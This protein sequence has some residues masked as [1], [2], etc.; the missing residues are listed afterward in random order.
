V[1]TTTKGQPLDSTVTIVYYLYRQAFEEFHFGY[2]SA[3]AY[4]VFAVTMVI[5]AGMIWYSRR[6]KFEAF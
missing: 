1:Y 2:G 6:A 5:T 4:G 3:I